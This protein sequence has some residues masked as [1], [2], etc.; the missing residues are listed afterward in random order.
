MNKKVL[1]IGHYKERGGWAQAA[2]DQILALDSVGVDIVCRN[3]T[4][5]QDKD[6]TDPKLLELEKKD[7]K[8]CD[9][10][11]QHVLPHHLIGTDKFRKNIAFLEIESTS[12]KSLAWFNHLQQ[13]TEVWV[14]NQDI[15]ESLKNDDFNVP[16]KLVP[17]TFN[18]DKYTKKY[19]DINI[20]DA[21]GKF[22]VC[23]RDR[24]RRHK[25]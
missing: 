3:V 12:I 14:P 16:V 23:I 13:M 21:E 22:K 18:I 25:R 20:P 4:L 6:S 9:L 1:Y 11:I 19:P 7:T 24:Y 15:L 2:T 8:D 17:H 10:C 5:T